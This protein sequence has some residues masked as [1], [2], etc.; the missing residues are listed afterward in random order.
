MSL[1]IICN[2]CGEE[3]TD[4]WAELQPGG[5]Y[6]DGKV[7]M[8]P[9]MYHTSWQYG[10]GPSED[11]CFGEALQLVR[12][13]ELRTPDAGYEWRLVPASERGRHWEQPDPYTTPVLGV[14]PLADLGLDD[15]T[16]KAMAK[17]GVFTVEHAVDARMRPDGSLIDLLPPKRLA[18]LD[19]ALVR[20][21]LIG[22]SEAVA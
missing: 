16:Y 14:T 15:A 19:A 1:S 13:M 22:G 4:H 20:G 11:C 2:W 12:G 8:R 18:Q 5:R 21:G 7:L 9:L 17:R 3:I 6:R 10:D